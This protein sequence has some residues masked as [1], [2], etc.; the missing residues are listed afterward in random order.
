MSIRDE[1][2]QQTRNTLL[3]AALSLMSDGRSFV[4]ISLRE[5]TREAGVVPT[6]FYRHFRD[7]DELGLALV[8]EV[9]LNLRRL[10]RE[11]RVKAQGAGHIAIK[12]SVMMFLLYVKQEA[13]YFD[14]LARERWSGS[15]KIRE[16]IQREI[17]HFSSDLSSDLRLFPEMQN[18]PSEDLQMISDLVIN[19]AMNWCGE[20]L[21]LPSEQVRLQYELSMQAV[22]Q[23]RL[24][25][26]GAKHW[27]ADKENT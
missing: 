14:F 27:R 8:D 11:E 20:I 15:S 18:L 9:C 22:K 19:T 26:V 25:F 23:L 12:S 21:S 17:R 2:K 7:M 6:A 4:S 1:K 24:I 3:E 5:V 10:L 16:A 13:R